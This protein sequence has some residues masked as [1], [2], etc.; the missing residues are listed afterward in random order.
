[1]N[2]RFPG[3]FVIGMLAIALGLVGVGWFASSAIKAARRSNDMVTVTGSARQT[4]KSDLATWAISVWCMNK[5]APPYDCAK[6]RGGQLYEFLKVH[7]VPDSSI[8]EGPISVEQM[9]EP[10]RMK[11][12][13]E[14]I[15]FKCSQRFE[16]HTT[17]VDSIDRLVKDAAA[18]IPELIEMN[19]ETPQYFYTKLS[20]MRVSLLAEATK[21][22]KK[23]AEIIAGSAGGKVGAIRNARMGVVQVTAPNSRDVRDYGIYDTSTIDKDI[24]AVVTVSFSVE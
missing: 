16:V 14:F 5:T 21:D 4:V 23:R 19:S 10:D 20:D 22:A 9:F 24:T 3:H 17:L 8:T 2:D 6:K 7:H 12:T 15:G 13:T 1:M 11:G 18:L